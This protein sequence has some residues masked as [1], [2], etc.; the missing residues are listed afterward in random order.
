MGQ[1]GGGPFPPVWTVFRPSSV[2]PHAPPRGKPPPPACPNQGPTLF[3]P[4]PTP[5]TGIDVFEARRSV[6]RPE[7]PECPASSPSPTSSS[8]DLEASSQPIAR[9][10]PAPWAA[11]APHVSSHTRRPPAATLVVT[12]ARAPV[13]RDRRRARPQPFGPSRPGAQARAAAAR[14]ELSRS[15]ARAPAARAPGLSPPPPPAYRR[16]AATAV[17]PPARAPEQREAEPPE[18]ERG[19]GAHDGPPRRPRR[20]AARR[21]RSSSPRLFPPRLPPLPPTPSPPKW[22][23]PPPPARGERGVVAPGSLPRHRLFCGFRGNRDGRPPPPPCST[24]AGPPPP[25][26]KSST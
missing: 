25:A 12:R 18:A 19:A 24:A 8:A 20:L 7:P 11:A 23:R 5:S 15:S 22:P 16:R 10:G 9:H 21:R 17:A 4:R 6:S 26:L 13:R 1:G 3:E 14:M 2:P